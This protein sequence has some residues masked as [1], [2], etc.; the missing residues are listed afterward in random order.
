MCDPGLFTTVDKVPLCAIGET[1]ARH[2]I[3]HCTYA[4]DR[5]RNYY[6]GRWNLWWEHEYSLGRE[7]D[8]GYLH[9]NEA[10]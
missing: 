6:Q 10:T 8:P 5:R 3:K 4:V 9:R 7:H 1:R 2:E